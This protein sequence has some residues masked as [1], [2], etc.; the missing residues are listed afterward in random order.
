MFSEIRSCRKK[1]VCAFCADESFVEWEFGM[2]KMLS[3]GLTTGK[4]RERAT[5]I[6]RKYETETISRHYT[7]GTLVGSGRVSVIAEWQRNW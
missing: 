7:I 6:E 1:R 4:D 2:V 5:C 3:E